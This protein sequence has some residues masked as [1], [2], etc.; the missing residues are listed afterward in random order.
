MSTPRVT[1]VMNISEYLY[2][3]YHTEAEAPAAPPASPD[4]ALALSEFA[5]GPGCVLAFACLKDVCLLEPQDAAPRV[6]TCPGWGRQR[7][8]PS[9]GFGLFAFVG[10]S[11]GRLLLF[12]FH[13]G[14]CTCT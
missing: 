12:P 13:H 1:P 8:S 5:C 14:A 2:T 11:L 10:G 4:A 7:T 6:T 3:Y 9:E